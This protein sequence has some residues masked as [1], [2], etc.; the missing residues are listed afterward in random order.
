MSREARNQHVNDLASRAV[1]ARIYNGD[2]LEVYLREIAALP[3]LSPEE[4]HQLALQ[5][6]EGDHTARHRLI[7]TNLRLVVTI[8]RRY[9]GYGMSLSDLVQEGNL[10]LMKAVERFDP[11]RGT[12]FSTYAG[13]WIRE[14][15]T[16]ALNNGARPVALSRHAF[17]RFRAL[18]GT[19]EAL[20]A[21]AGREPTLSE[22]AAAAGTS[23]EQA[24]RIV[25][26]AAF[27]A[28]WLAAGE[29]EQDSSLLEEVACECGCDPAQAMQ[30]DSSWEQVRNAIDVALDPR[31]RWII[32][33]Y[34]GL[35]GTQPRRLKELAASM[36]ISVE[37][38]R[39]LRER[40]L[41]KL[42]KHVAGSHKA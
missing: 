28:T 23:R 31:E 16:R 41:T 40:A 2:P 5:A 33:Q 9:A 10:G 4:E 1:P 11:Q 24:G 20:T 25:T 3:L 19:A 36:G 22:V 27:P 30:E 21:M 29:E 8:A 6:A 17:R 14:S 13:Y 35:H 18:S 38:V 32:V 37:R 7:L 34:F 15:I 42:R 39:Q 12:R 26:A